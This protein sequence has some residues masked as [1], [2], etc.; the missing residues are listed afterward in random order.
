MA[1]RYILVMSIEPINLAFNS[2]TWPLDKLMM[3]I[4]FLSIISRIS[5]LDLDWPMMLRTSAFEV[6]CPTLF[7]M[8]GVASAA[9]RS[10]YLPN[11]SIQKDL[12]EASV[13]LSTTFFLYSLSESILLMPRRVE[14]GYSSKAMM[15]YWRIYDMRALQASAQIFSKVAMRPF[16]TRWRLSGS[17]S[18]MTLKAIGYSIS[19]GA[20]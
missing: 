14:S 2:P 5:K 9:N 19:N 16:T 10:V 3:S 12:A 1:A 15:A 13:I 18:S 6:N 17:T 7:W 8:A 4:F 20:K 11:S